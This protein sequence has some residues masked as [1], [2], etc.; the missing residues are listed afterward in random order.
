[1][2]LA[3]QVV[4]FLLLYFQKIY[5]TEYNR[6]RKNQRILK[7]MGMNKPSAENITTNCNTFITPPDFANYLLIEASSRPLIVEDDWFRAH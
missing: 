3:K 1:M 2:N 6:S 4:G 5:N 7:S